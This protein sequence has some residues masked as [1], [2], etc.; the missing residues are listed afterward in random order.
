VL[1]WLIVRQRW[2]C[3]L[4]RLLISQHRI[5]PQ[6]SR[7]LPSLPPIDSNP[8]HTV[9]L[10]V[11]E[12]SPLQSAFPL[13]STLLP[14]SPSTTLTQPSESPFTSH[15]SIEHLSLSSLPSLPMVPHTPLVGPT[16]TD[17]DAHM[18][19]YRARSSTYSR[20]T[21]PS[22]HCANPTMPSL[23]DPTLSFNPTRILIPLNDHPSPRGSPKVHLPWLRHLHIN[24]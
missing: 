11:C 3:L 19:T 17:T 22:P 8:K 9:P 6:R 4:L 14:S 15:L 1:R 23:T 7:L 21:A 18:D 10:P 13:S 16:L 2:L 24:Y 5:H 12:D 20:N